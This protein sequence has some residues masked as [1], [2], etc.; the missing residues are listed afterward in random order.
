[1]RKL[2]V[3][4]PPEKLADTQEL[5]RT[6]NEEF[7]PKNNRGGWLRPLEIKD[8]FLKETPRPEPKK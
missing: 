4:V 6:W 8:G 3:P 5:V 7:L 2:R 1:M